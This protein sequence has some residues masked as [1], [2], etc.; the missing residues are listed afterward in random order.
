MPYAFLT[1]CKEEEFH[2]RHWAFPLESQGSLSVEPDPASCGSCH[3]KQFGSWKSTLHSRA[4]GPGFLWQLPRLGKHSTEKCTNCHSPNLETKNIL[5][6]RLGWEEKIQDPKWKPGIEENGIQCASCH[7]RNG[8]IYGPIPK[9][10]TSERIVENSNI[11]HEGF[12]PKKEFEE[13]EFCKNC[14]QSPNTA[15][16]VN[17]KFLMDTYGQWKRSEFGK[18]KIHC[19]NCHMPDRNHE[20]KGISDPEMVSRGIQTS[21]NVLASGENFEVVA[22]LKNSGVGH[23][24]PSYS[25]P[26]VYL[27]VW[28]ETKSGKRNK[29][30]EKILG[31]MLDLELQTEIFDTRLSPGEATLLKTK[32]TRQEFQEIRKIQFVVTVDP[33]EYYKRMFAD[34]WKFKDTFPENTKPWVLPYL[35]KALEEAN[36]SKYEFARLEWKP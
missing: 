27:E 25:V 3:S 30:S 11:P 9:N 6:S 21:L 10:G 26:K 5:L 17:G 13:A 31:W 24:F 15:K 29:I 20:W 19:Q 36:S 16:P 35:K 18:N 12:I 33:K 8:K 14:H 34:N 1:Y 22:E 23:L 32:L 4:L 7:L 2:Q 28:A